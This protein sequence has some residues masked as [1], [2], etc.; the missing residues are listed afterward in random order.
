MAHQMPSAPTRSCAPPTWADVRSRL[1]RAVIRILSL[2]GA[3]LLLAGCVGSSKAT[4]RTPLTIAVNAPFS[5]SPYLGRTIENGARLAASEV[6]A[7][8]L[9]IGDKT[10]ELRVTTMDTALSPARAVSN[11]RRAVGQHA[12]AVV[13]EGTGIDASW[14]VASGD[15]MPVG[16]VFEGGRQ[17]VDPVAR[18]NVFRIAPSDHGIAFRLAEYLIPK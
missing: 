2:S 16:I 11:M 12:I 1:A 8:G 17:L 7:N 4:N 3:L 14:R 15:G 10:Y 18:P 13:D 9:R 5:R 6:N